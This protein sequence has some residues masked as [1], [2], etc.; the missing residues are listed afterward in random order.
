M[1]GRKITPPKP[2]EP[3][4]PSDFMEAL[5]QSA[6][7]DSEARAEKRKPA[8]RKTTKSKT[9]KRRKAA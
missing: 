6:R 2:P 7:G 9:T 5:R 4:R 3:T 1:E 8:P